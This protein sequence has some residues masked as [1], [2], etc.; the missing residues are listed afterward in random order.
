MGG[1]K[2]MVF[3]RGLAWWVGERGMGAGDDEVEGEEDG[4]RRGGVGLG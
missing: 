4:G 1:W 2:V 3:G